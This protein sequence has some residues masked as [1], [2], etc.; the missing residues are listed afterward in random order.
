MTSCAAWTVR[1]RLERSMASG[2][3]RA[4][5]MVVQMANSIAVGVLR[6]AVSTRTR[7][8]RTV[9]QMGISAAARMGR[10]TASGRLSG[11]AAASRIL[12]KNP[13]GRPRGGP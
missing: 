5:G 9:L 2:M 4:T 12:V 8:T 7:M 6:F 13:G 1:V 11:V 3:S 10:S